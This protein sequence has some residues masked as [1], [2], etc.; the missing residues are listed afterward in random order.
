MYRMLIAIISPPPFIIGK[1]KNTIAHTRHKR[2][3]FLDQEFTFKHWT[4]SCIKLKEQNG[5]S[6]AH[7]G[8]GWKF[9]KVSYLS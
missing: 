2:L 8:Y 3:V 1:A 6:H 5:D 7:Q 9:M 4:G